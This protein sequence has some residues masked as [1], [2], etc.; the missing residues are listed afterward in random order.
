L[1]QISFL[2][3]CCSPAA[4][5]FGNFFVTPHAQLSLKYLEHSCNPA[6]IHALSSLL[7][8]PALPLKKLKA[9]VCFQLSVTA[10]SRTAIG[11]NQIYFN[12]V[13]TAFC[14]PNFIKWNKGSHLFCAIV[15]LFTMSGKPKTNVRKTLAVF[16][17][18]LRQ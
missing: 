6:I 3:G 16:F 13:H 2:L 9:S 15:H 7:S 11:Q 8:W 1:Q 14:S 5:A 18:H 12:L 17:L 10:E 4:I